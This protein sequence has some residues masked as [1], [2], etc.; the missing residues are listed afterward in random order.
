MTRGQARRCICRH[1]PG[2]L[3]GAAATS[4]ATDDLRVCGTGLRSMCNTLRPG[5][6]PIAGLVYGRRLEQVAARPSRR[7]GA[8]A[9]Y[10]GA[11]QPGSVRWPGPRARHGYTQAYLKR[12]VRRPAVPAL[13]ACR[14]GP[15]YTR[16]AGCSVGR[17]LPA[18]RQPTPPQK[19]PRPPAPPPPPKKRWADG[20]VSRRRRRRRRRRAAGGCGRRGA[21]AAAAARGGTACRPWRCTCSSGTCG[22]GRR[23]RRRRRLRRWSRRVGLS[24]SVRLSVCLSVCLS[25][26]LPPTP[27]WRSGAGPGGA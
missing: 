5:K 10:P 8:A 25:V 23:R 13:T 2:P 26:S 22:P 24:L 19:E 3:G 12:L 27:L 18:G 16:P 6:Q 15:S 14:R 4:T 9:S 17:R 21:A 1:G 20:V 11:A 7:S